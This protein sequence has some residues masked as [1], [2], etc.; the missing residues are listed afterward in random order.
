MVRNLA[1]TTDLA[2][3]ART[4]VKHANDR[5]VTLADVATVTWGL[6]PMRGD[7]TVS[8]APEKRPPTASSCRSPSPPASTPAPSPHK[9][10]P[11][12]PS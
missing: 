4:V 10:P 12:S 2:E 3:L 11:R 1:M 8:V 6:E 5:T 7:A 9:S